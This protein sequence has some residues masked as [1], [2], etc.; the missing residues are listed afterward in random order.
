MNNLF[1]VHGENYS[2]SRTRLTSLIEEFKS[3]NT[4]EVVKLDGK[5]VGLEKVKQALESQSLFGNERLVV[6][7]NLLTGLASKRQKEIIVYLLGETH[8]CPLILWEKKEVK[9]SLLDKFKV[10]FQIAIFKIPAT[11]F[12]F[13]DSLSPNNSR[14]TIGWLR[15]T[16]Q[17]N[18]E[19]TFHM[20]CQRVRQLILTKDLGKDG[21]GKLQGWQKARLLSQANRFA[22]DQLVCLYRQL[23]E[24]DYQR[25]VGQISFSLLSALDLLLADL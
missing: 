17:K 19:F 23:L 16:D 14:Q 24:I 21:L 25:K 13:L 3:K 20:L 12:K 4:Q 7:E 1:L 8:R 6:I 9:K 2:Q 18:P 15:Q 10:K 22:L 11:V 5:G